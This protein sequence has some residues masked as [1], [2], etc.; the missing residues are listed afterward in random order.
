[1]SKKLV[2][3]TM[4]PFGEER[5]PLLAFYYA[6]KPSPKLRDLTKHRLSEDG[7]MEVLD[8]TRMVLDLGLRPPTLQEQI[9][10]LEAVGKLARGFYDEDRAE[11][12]F[13]ENEEDLPPEGLTQYEIDEVNRGRP[14]KPAKKPDDKPATPPP[15][16]S[17]PA[18]HKA[19]DP[20]SK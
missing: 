7:S 13:G 4:V 11:D 20:P 3:P 1:M 5:H 12:D 6:H 19:G 10:R 8:D 14:K 2:V 18:P 15:A 9:A 17:D 16:P